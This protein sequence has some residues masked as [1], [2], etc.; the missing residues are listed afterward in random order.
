MYAGC[1]SFLRR[2][3]AGSVGIIEISGG[4]T[5]G[6]NKRRRKINLYKGMFNFASPLTIMR[7]IKFR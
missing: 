4:E 3:F 7:L 6:T 2:D 1:S 5:D